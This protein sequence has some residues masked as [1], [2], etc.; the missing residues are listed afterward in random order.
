M[1]FLTSPDIPLLVCG[2]IAFYAAIRALVERDIPK[3]L[4]YLNVFGFAISG[5]FVLLFPDIL[6]AIAAVAFFV[7]TT[8]E[9]NIIA[10][11][12]AR[13]R[14]RKSPGTGEEKP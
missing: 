14:A 10:S 5:S 1:A 11:A 12:I 9:G 7:G 13:K 3:K 2:C 6:T 8:L 4:L